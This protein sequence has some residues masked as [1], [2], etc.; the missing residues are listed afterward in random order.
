[1]PGL[2][3][4]PVYAQVIVIALFMV[5]LKFRG[6]RLPRGGEGVAR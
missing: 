3:T 2:N 6:N 1:M 4:T 5:I